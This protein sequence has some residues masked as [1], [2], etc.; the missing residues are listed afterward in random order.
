MEEDCPVNF[1]FLLCRS[2]K[3]MSLKSGMRESEQES[4]TREV[5]AEGVVA[6]SLARRLLELIGKVPAISIPG[7][8][9]C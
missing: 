4:K 8:G 7:G 3:G 9:D 1:T 2:Y 5:L 6:T